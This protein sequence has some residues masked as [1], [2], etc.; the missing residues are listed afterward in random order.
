MRATSTN[1]S[2]AMGND[3]V[4]I[5]HLFERFPKTTPSGVRF[6]S[7][8]GLALL[9]LRLVRIIPI[10]RWRFAT[11]AAVAFEFSNLFFESLDLDDQSQQQGGWNRHRSPGFSQFFKLLTHE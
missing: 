6:A 8:L 5:G 9:L 3:S 1:P 10:R 7:A 4:R 2:Q 11:G